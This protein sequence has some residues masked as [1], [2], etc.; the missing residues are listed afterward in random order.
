MD[1]L[2]KDFWNRFL[3]KTSR[4]KN[5]TYMDVF[6]FELTE[7]VSNEL[8]DLVLKGQ[9]RATASSYSSYKIEGIPLPKK[10]DLSIVTNFQGV[11][12][13]V[14]QTKEVSIIPFKEITYD[15]CKR[16]GEDDT[17]ESW[18]KGHIKFFT[19]EGKL[20]GYEFCRNMLVVFEDF[21][22]VYTE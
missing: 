2:I 20:L 18:Q 17:L 10:G 7:K 13:C 22:V 9:K 8:L 21:E 15:I 11:P 16:E 12:K 3:E 4:N 5:T 6:Y 14:I 19:E 1:E